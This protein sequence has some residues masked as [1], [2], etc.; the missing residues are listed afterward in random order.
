M[1][2]IMYEGISYANA[3]V[4]SDATSIPT[5]DMTA[6]FDSTAHMNSTDMTSQE[7]SDFVD[8]LDAQGTNLA[9]YVV[10]QGTSGIWT[11]RKWN[12]GIAECWGYKQTSGTFS[13]W[14]SIYS[15]D[16]PAEAYP[17]GLF[18]EAPT[19][20]GSAKCTGGNS[21]GGINTNGGTKDSA[22]GFTLVRGTAL[23]GTLDFIAYW[24]AKGRW[25]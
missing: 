12:S 2:K 6:A 11:Y 20:V 17:S 18:I 8:N 9:D 22:C 7:V 19:C 13:T 24:V 1:S 23:S 5:A 3:G 15:H 25:K 21:A 4:S 14:G 10:E 16:V